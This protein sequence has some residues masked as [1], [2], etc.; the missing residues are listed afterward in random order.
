MEQLLNSGYTFIL[1]FIFSNFNIAQFE[2]FNILFINAQAINGLIIGLFLHTYSVSNQKKIDLNIILFIFLSAVVILPIIDYIFPRSDIKINATEQYILVITLCLNELSRWVLLKTVSIL[3][4]FIISAIRLLSLLLFLPL[5][6]SAGFGYELIIILYCLHPCAMLIKNQKCI[7]FKF[8]K[9]TYRQ[10]QYKLN[11]ALSMTYG[12]F[13]NNYLANIGLINILAVASIIRNIVSPITV[14]AQFFDNYFSSHS[15]TSDRSGK[16]ITFGMSLII[17]V[18]LLLLASNF[19]P[20]EILN[21]YGL[22]SF[23]LISLCVHNLNRINISFLRRNSEEGF[24]SR[25]SFLI[26]M[27]SVSFIL[28]VS[29][30]GARDELVYIIFVLPFIVA[31]QYYFETYAKPSNN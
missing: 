2:V 26:I 8:S 6:F 4:I 30:N 9:F 15:L 3:W 20:Q 24:F 12:L 5:S 11:Y 21:Q 19:Y 27:I 25:N 17:G 16:L 7:E 1:I 13:I 28:F 23:I 10:N 22:M 18:M 29:L 14:F 31:S